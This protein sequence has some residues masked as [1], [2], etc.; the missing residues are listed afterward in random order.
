MFTF[1]KFTI[2][3]SACAMKVGTDGVLLGAWA[4]HENTKRILDIGTGSGLIAIMLAQ[5][6]VDASIE[7]IDIDPLSVSQA[8]KNIANTPFMDRIKVWEA[9]F[10]TMDN[11]E[12]YDLIVSNPP[13]YKEQTTCP[14]AK[15]DA[16]RHTSSLPFERLI[17]QARM[18]LTENGRFCVIIPTS[19]V[20]DFIGTAARYKL[21]LCQRTDVYTTPRKQPK[22]T[23]LSF[24]T[25]SD[26]DS[27]FKKLYI[28]NVENEFSNEYKELGKD[29]YLDF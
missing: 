24:T 17:E 12:K 19:A 26:T 3:D 5:R 28:R 6:F 4:K 8:E 29:F 11:N 9:D 16:A 25:T 1:K 22:R 27:K 2:D 18:K 10:T 13:F 14:D 21:Y 15:R 7:A 23:L 20:T